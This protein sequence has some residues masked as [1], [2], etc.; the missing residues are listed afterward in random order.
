MD[1]WL[2]EG[3]QDILKARALPCLVQRVFF[4]F[5]F[6]DFRTPES[7]TAVKIG[8]RRLWRSQQGCWSE[9]NQSDSRDRIN[10]VAEI[11]Y[12]F[13]FIVWQ[14][15][16]GSCCGTCRINGLFLSYLLRNLMMQKSYTTRP[17][18]ESSPCRIHRLHVLLLPAREIG[19]TGAPPV[20]FFF[21]SQGLKS[22][23]LNCK[24]Y[25]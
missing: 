9:M 24:L 14:I 4:L 8:S 7:R 19:S 22:M 20:F 2:D 18:T 11:R 13:L 12:G 3:G 15:S 16:T 25:L 10:T 21:C 1:R 6:L 5:L 17:T 23:V